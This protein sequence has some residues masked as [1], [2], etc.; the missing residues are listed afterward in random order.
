MRDKNMI[1]SSRSSECRPKCRHLKLHFCMGSCAGHYCKFRVRVTCEEIAHDTMVKTSTAHNTAS[2]KLPPVEAVFDYVNQQY[3]GGA[4]T[5]RLQGA[6]L[7]YRYI[8]R[9]LQ[10]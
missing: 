10:A 9:Q 5:T 3:V 6:E 4:S 7:A 1:C 2:L 8:E